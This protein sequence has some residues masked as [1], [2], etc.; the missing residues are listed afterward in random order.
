MP[1]LV[2]PLLPRMLRCFLPHA[3]PASFGLLYSCGKTRGERVSP[4]SSTSSTI[5]KDPEHDDDDDE[6][7]DEDEE[8]VDDDGVM[9]LTA[10]SLFC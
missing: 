1:V 10:L 8:D 4:A 9:G 7:E 6:D 3:L 5:R 2:V